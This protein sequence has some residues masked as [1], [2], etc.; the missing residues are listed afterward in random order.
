MLK[1]LLFIGAA[2][3]FIAGSC[4]MFQTMI[5]S[6]FPYTTT[7]VI[8]AASKTGKDYVATSIATSFDQN[9]SK[10]G[11]NGDRINQVRIV[12]ARLRSTKPVDYN[13]G[14]L[15]SAKIYAAKADGSGEI[16]VATRT[17]ITANAGND[18]VL[19]INNSEFLDELVREPNITVR[20]VYRLRAAVAN[21]V[22]LQVIL[23][24]G[25][26]PGN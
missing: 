2:L 8:P 6:T 14:N 25:A 24:L 7:L 12:S 15:V 26:N 18:I 11:N 4:G 22:S 21:D 13:I 17:D 23:G 16:L 1:R 19:D 3:C 10:S 20:M 9:F 5:K